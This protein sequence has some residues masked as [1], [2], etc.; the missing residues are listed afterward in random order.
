MAD[1]INWLFVIL[2]H[3]VIR[4]TLPSESIEETRIRMAT[5][6]LPTPEN[7]RIDNY[8]ILLK[9]SMGSNEAGKPRLIGTIGSYRVNYDAAAIGYGLHPEYW[10]RG[11]GT[12]AL[13]LFIELYW[14]SGRMFSDSVPFLFWFEKPA[15]MGVERRSFILI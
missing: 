10:G 14:A 5:K 8:A 1:L 15:R 2:P 9:S 13:K 3:N 11:Y 7:P 6:A 12:E 4:P